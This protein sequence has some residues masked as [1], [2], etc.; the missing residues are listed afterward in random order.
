MSIVGSQKIRPFSLEG[1]ESSIG[2][3][4]LFAQPKGRKNGLDRVKELEGTVTG[5]SAG[6]KSH[7]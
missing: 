1:E 5:Y 3:K 4:L 2:H 7:V 6:N